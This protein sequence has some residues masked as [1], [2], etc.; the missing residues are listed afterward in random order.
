M[1]TAVFDTLKASRTLK[2][3]GIDEAQADAI[4]T[5]MAEAF[6]DAVATKSDLAVLKAELLAAFSNGINRM[7]IAQLAVAGLLFA[8]LKLF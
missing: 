4:V 7:L 3:A 8:A 1:S 2:A 5:T 6:D